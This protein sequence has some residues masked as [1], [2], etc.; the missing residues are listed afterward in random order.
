MATKVVH[1]HQHS[2][3]AFEELIRPTLIANNFSGNVLIEHPGF[4][5]YV[6]YIPRDALT[7][8][9]FSNIYSSA[10][11]EIGDGLART[12]SDFRT[13][14]STRWQK[15]PTQSKALY[16]SDSRQTSISP[17]PK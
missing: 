15:L 9:V 16:D 5:S 10:P 12:F 13:R 8:I 2:A 7:V 17:M 6:L 3:N 11:S 4:T 1:Q 14:R